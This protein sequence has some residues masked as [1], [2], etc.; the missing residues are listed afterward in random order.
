MRR[1]QV[2]S[3][4]QMSCSKSAAH[5][6]KHRMDLSLLWLKLHLRC[7]PG[8][9][10]CIEKSLKVG[11]CRSIRIFQRGMQLIGSRHC[12]L[13][14]WRYR[15]VCSHWFHGHPPEPRPRVSWSTT[16]GGMRGCSRMRSSRMGRRWS[17][18][19]RSDVGSWCS[20]MRHRCS[21]MGRR[22]C[23]GSWCSCMRRRCSGMG[24]RSCMGSR[25]CW[26]RRRMQGSR[27]MGTDYWNRCVPPRIAYWQFR[28]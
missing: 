2:L 13:G 27:R 28:G 9:F 22:S 17:G 7:I 1:R 10:P 16:T 20:C 4:L 14:W 11:D 26:R 25:W 6:Q 8:C 18:V 23:M 15:L 21:G 19:L 5:I 12:F 24:R 3:L